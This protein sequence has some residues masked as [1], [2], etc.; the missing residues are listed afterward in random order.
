M[1]GTDEGG[2]GS[3]APPAGT[4]TSAALGGP[5]VSLADRLG[6]SAVQVA[7]QLDNARLSDSLPSAAGAPPRQLL[8]RPD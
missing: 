5:A 7:R 4:G 2:G 6:A 1:R 3:M 8:S